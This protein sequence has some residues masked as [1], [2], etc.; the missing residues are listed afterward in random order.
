MLSLLLP[1]ISPVSRDKVL[2]RFANYC[3]L[4]A[5]SPD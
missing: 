2:P 5:S 4:W 1:L 3:E